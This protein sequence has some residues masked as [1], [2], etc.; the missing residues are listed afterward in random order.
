[1]TTGTLPIIFHIVKST[2]AAHAEQVHLRDTTLFALLI[3]S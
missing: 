3:H 2:S 1:M